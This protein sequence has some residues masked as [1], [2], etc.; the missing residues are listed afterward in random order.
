MTYAKSK[1]HHKDR[2][3]DI[4]GCGANVKIMGKFFE[5]WEIDV[6]GQGAEEAGYCNEG[7]DV[8]FRAGVKALYGGGWGF[9]GEPASEGVEG[10]GTGNF[11]GP[12]EVEVK[13][14]ECF[15]GS[16]GFPILA[17]LC[18]ISCSHVAVVKFGSTSLHYLRASIPIDSKRN[19][20]DQ[21]F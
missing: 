2:D 11:S 21:F 7:E 13:D 19:R 6:A 16:E 14:A 8:C 4:D 17:D 9:A 5:G 12:G 20:F 10:E 1:Y 18:V 15:S 3:G